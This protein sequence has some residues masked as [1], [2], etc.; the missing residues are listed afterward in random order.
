MIRVFL[1]ILLSYFTVFT[2][3]AKVQDDNDNYRKALNSY[4]SQD[5]ESLLYQDVVKVAQAIVHNRKSYSDDMVAKAFSL[6]SD[7]AFNRGDLIAAL[8]FAHFGRD[9]ENIKITIK[10]D[11]LLKVARGYYSQGKY[12]ELRDISQE[13]S[14]LAEQAGNMNY[15]LQ[16]SAYAVVA[17][18]LSADYAL[19]VSELSNVEYLLSQNQ[20]R[21]EQIVLLEIIAEAHFYLAEYSNATELLNQV[22]KLRVEMSKMKG[23]ARTYHLLAKTY[24]Q[25][26]QYDNAFHAY[27]QS[28]QLSSKYGLNIRASNA[29]LGLGKV[30]YQQ[31]NFIQS[32]VHLNTA[33]A[34]FDRYNLSRTKLS[35]QIVLAKVHYALNE[36]EQATLLLLSAE[37]IATNIV[38][39]S[40]QIELYLLLARHYQSNNNFEQVIKVQRRY[41]EL[42]QAFNSGVNA[43]QVT[44][45]EA[46]NKSQDLALNLAEQSTL[47][48]KFDE[49]Y[50]R[51]TVLI[52]L[53]LILLSIVGALFV[54][55]YIRGYRNQLYQGYDAIELPKNRLA[56][57]VKTKQWYQQQYKMARKYQYGISV[58]YLVVDNWQELNFHFNAK[59]LT[60][61][62][63][64]IAIIVNENLE[65]EDFSGEL[66]VGEYLFLC[67]YQDTEEMLI[68]LTRIKLA[69]N[70]RFFA[71]LG[72]YSVKVRFSI[73]SPNIQDIDPYVFLS[74][75][76][77][78]IDAKSVE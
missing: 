37:N 26:Q 12:N 3:Q 70:T 27:W 46:S 60:D 34:I 57:P 4:Y 50:Y 18:A 71:N 72:D 40:E 67:P 58:A 49:K 36:L 9:I 32:K 48:L 31:Q 24:Y 59:I 74:R 77:D 68:K 30:L 53:L 54:F 11:L 51:Q 15:H 66:S 13:T 1:Y 38:L 25:Q 29:E 23:I 44:A 7:I 10:L 22:L 76:S 19:A 17:Y 47:R 2:S 65:E 6:L 56:A 21:V 52:T 73:A 62:Y 28:K 5:K 8:Q 39:T 16:A 78:S 41:I 55:R 14:W 64:A 42:Y 63:Q 33:L 45:S 43:M 35:T 75:L 61:V 69:I 20:H